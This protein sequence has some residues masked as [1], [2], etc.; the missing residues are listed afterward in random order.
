MSSLASA[1]ELTMAPSAPRITVSEAGTASGPKEDLD[2]ISGAM[3]ALP[4]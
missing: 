2:W 1:G 3:L 4:Q